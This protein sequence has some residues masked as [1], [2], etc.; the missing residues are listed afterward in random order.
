[1]GGGSGARNAAG[2]LQ[3]GGKWCFADSWPPPGTQEQYLYLC[4][5]GTLRDVPADVDT[6]LEYRFDPTDPVPTIGGALTSGEPLMQGGAFDQR[7]TR[8]VFS[9][10]EHDGEE[11]LA[12]RQDVL[13]F[14]T[15]PLLDALTVSGAIR[16]ELCVSSNCPDTDFTAK[17]IDVYPPSADYPQGFAMNITDGIFRMR[18]RDG[19]DRESMIVPGEVY[20]IGIEPFATSNLFNAGHRL[21]IDISSSNYPH[22]DLNPNTGAAEGCAEH[23]RVATNRVHLGKTHASRIRLPLGK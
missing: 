17:L 13:V 21:R 12:N 15:P 23:F 9:Y 8:Q 1:M 4:P 20:R 18:Y 19:W 7:Q 3:H 14:Q 16:I 11:D 5:D 22:F 2:R 6:Y 10:R